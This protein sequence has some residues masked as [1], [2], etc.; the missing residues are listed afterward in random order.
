MELP[1]SRY[2]LW[3]ERL[4]VYNGAV[5]HALTLELEQVHAAPVVDVDQAS[6]V[7][8]ASAPS[9]PPPHQ[10]LP[11]GMTAFAVDGVAP[12]MDI[13]LVAAESQRDSDG[14]QFPEIEYV[15]G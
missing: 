2:F 3:A 8:S 9:V 1:S 4:P 15:G 11:K 13:A 7:A 6:T 12:E 5:R 10:V 14:G